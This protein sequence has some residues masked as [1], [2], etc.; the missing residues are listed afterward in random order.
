MKLLV[1][2][3]YCLYKSPPPGATVLVITLY[4]EFK[5][6]RIMYL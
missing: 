5:L 2:E 1:E 6:A 3:T 4:L